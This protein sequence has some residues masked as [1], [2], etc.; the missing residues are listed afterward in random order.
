VGL[1][2]CLTLVA[3]LLQKFVLQPQ[4]ESE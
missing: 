1:A 2:I 4:K 3:L